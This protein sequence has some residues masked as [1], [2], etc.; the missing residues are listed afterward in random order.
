MAQVQPTEPEAEVDAILLTVEW[1]EGNARRSD[2][3]SRLISGTQSVL[4]YWL[5]AVARNSGEEVGPREEQQFLND[6]PE[7]TFAD[8][9]AGSIDALIAVIGG[10]VGGVAAAVTS[11]DLVRRA[12]GVIR[13]RKNQGG[14]FG[15]ADLGSAIGNS[16]GGSV[17]IRSLE[18]QKALPPERQA[19]V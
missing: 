16:V 15:E 6:L 5:L 3:V 14:D 2:D 12:I 13:R 11:V 10:V 7:L 19:E 18:T 17:T 8:V 9:R 4:G 1:E